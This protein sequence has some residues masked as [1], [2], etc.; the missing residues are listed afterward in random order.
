MHGLEIKLKDQKMNFTTEYTEKRGQANNAA[1][2]IGSKRWASR[3][4]NLFKR[5]NV[6]YRTRNFECRRKREN[7]EKKEKLATDPHGHFTRA[8]G[9]AKGRHR[10][11]KE[12]H[13]SYV[14]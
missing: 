10:L 1:Q 4:P 5:L 8:I 9:S 7:T 6:E 13:L 12:G 11:A 2:N 14:Y 3:P